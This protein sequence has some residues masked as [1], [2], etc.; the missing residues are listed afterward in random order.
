MT[1]PKNAIV[2]FDEIDQVVGAHSF[3]LEKIYDD[4]FDGDAHETMYLPKLIKKWP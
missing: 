3:Y 2:I 4:K 1:P